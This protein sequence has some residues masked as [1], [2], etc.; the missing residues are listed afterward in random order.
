MIAVEVKVGN[1]KFAWEFVGV[2]RAP[3]EDMRVIEML[4][5]RTGFPLN[6]TKPSII[7]GDL[8]LPYADWIRNAVGNSGSQ[9][10]MNNLVWENGYSQAIDSRTR[11]DALWTFTC[12]DRK[13]QSL[14]AVQYR[15]S[16]II[17]Q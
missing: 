12:S 9:A 10:L 11:G 1:P 16:V 5:A 2:Y 8:N 14:L 15:G 17:L 6:S 7:G 4:T 13:V 3:N